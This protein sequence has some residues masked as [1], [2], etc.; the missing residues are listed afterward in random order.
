MFVD[1]A[2][3]S[4][5]C[6][7]SDELA[8]GTVARGRHSSVGSGCCPGGGVCYKGDLLAP[9]GLRGAGGLCGLLQRRLGYELRGTVR[10][11]FGLFV[12]DRID[13]CHRQL[14]QETAAPISCQQQFLVAIF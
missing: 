12:H 3:S 2:R 14:W 5:L 13:R 6:L 10:L 11:H 4:C 1:I 7:G 9:A 8:Y